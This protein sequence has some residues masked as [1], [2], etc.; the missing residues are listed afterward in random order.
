MKQLDGVDLWAV[1]KAN[2]YGHGSVAVAQA[3]LEVGAQGLCVA[4]VQE[5]MALRRKFPSERIL[6][7]GPIASND[8]P[9]IRDGH[10]ECV[11]H[12]DAN[13]D[14]LARDTVKFHIKLN[15]G[16]NR[17][18][19]SRVPKRIPGHVVG[20]MSQLAT[21][22][23]TAITYRQLRK[24]LE[25]TEEASHVTRHIANS[26]AA[27]L[28]PET[29]LD[30]VRA[31]CSLVGFPPVPGVDVGLKP[32]LR[33]TSYVAQVRNLSRGESIGYE[34][35]FAL[36]ESTSIALIPVGYADGFSPGLVGSEVIVGEE[37]AKVVA[38]YMD[39]MA[40]TLPKRVPS[41]TPVVLI[42]DGISLADHSESSGI[43]GWK[44]SSCLVDDARRIKRRVI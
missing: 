10:L 11:A 34:E 41:G 38:I 26:C 7:M 27:W 19:V 24:F 39:A 30:A 32:A 9:L 35:A 42:G 15:T 31:G 44:I 17:W 22:G 6:I 43:D 14:A 23:D 18:G 28:F 36:A 20:I 21:D 40:V 5:A 12:D 25:L 2:A 13:L 3:A 33:W 4:T 37:R 1:V 29:H 8:L 16:L